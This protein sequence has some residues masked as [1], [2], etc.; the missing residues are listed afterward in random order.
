MLQ[1]KCPNPRAATHLT[2]KLLTELPTVNERPTVKLKT[3]NRR[4]STAD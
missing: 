1:L 3:L 2:A 4:L